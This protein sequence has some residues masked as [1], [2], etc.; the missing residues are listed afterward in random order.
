MSEDGAGNFEVVQDQVLVVQTQVSVHGAI[1]QNVHLVKSV[2][3]VE[4][5]LALLEEFLL[6]FVHESLEGVRAQVLKVDNVEELTLEPLLVFVLVLDQA[7]IELL[8]D[9]GEDV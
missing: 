2:S 3:V 5:D 6:E 1:C 9:V 7:V 4:D 8:L